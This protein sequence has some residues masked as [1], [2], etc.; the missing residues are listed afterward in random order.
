MKHKTIEFYLECYNE[1]VYVTTSQKKSRKAYE[2][3]E[4]AYRRWILNIGNL[5]EHITCREYICQ[6]LDENRIK[7]TIK[8]GKGLRIYEDESKTQENLLIVDSVFYNKYIKDNKEKFIGEYTSDDTTDLYEKA[9]S[10]NAIL[11]QVEICY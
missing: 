5:Y 8:Y 1:Y 9:L 6:E 3:M 10:A 11:N 7:Y 2:V 4:K